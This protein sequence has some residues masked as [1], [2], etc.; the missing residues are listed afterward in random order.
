MDSPKGFIIESL[1]DPPPIFPLIER[2]GPVAPE[3]MY[4]V[5]NM[6]IG[7]CVVVSPEG[8]ARVQ[9]IARA[10]GCEAWRIGYCVPDPD[11][12]VWIKPAALVGQNGRFSSE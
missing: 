2:T 7:F 9:E 8:A 1:P 10:A 6:G 4:R 11:K 12:R 3:E 5:Y